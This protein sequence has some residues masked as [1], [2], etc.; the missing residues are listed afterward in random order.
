MLLFCFYA[1]T[2]F[3][4]VVSRNS[5]RQWDTFKNVSFFSDSQTE[6][7]VKTAILSAYSWYPN[8]YQMGVK[9]IIIFFFLN[10]AL[11]KKHS[12]SSILVAKLFGLMEKELEEKN[13]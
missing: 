2:Y 1:F 4:P 5:S 13:G 6:I 12:C 10:I 7:K 8:H 9:Y 11:T 3:L